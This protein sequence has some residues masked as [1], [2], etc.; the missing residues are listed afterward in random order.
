MK[1][2]TLP[3]K[4]TVDSK[5][6]SAKDDLVMSDLDI[7]LFAERALLASKDRDSAAWLPLMEDI[8]ATGQGVG[9]LARLTGRLGGLT[10]Q[11]MLVNSL[12]VLS[13][14]SREDY[15]DLFSRVEGELGLY[16]LEGVF[17]QLGGLSRSAVA[18]LLG[19]RREPLVLD[20]P[21]RFFRLGMEGELIE[22]EGSDRVQ[23][24]AKRDSFLHSDRAVLA[25]YR[26]HL[27]ALLAA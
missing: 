12:P 1:K 16:D 5:G 3:S 11:M 4:R 20:W 24:A 18:T 13:K 7:E 22:L 21:G 14:W 17:W 9:V 15:L 8:M 27:R 19:G 10:L 23:A 25:S 26:E 6:S 2:Q